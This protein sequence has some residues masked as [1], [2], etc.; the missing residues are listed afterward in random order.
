MKLAQKLAVNYLRARLNITAVV[1]K[2][3]AA[4]KAF[5]IFCTP[6]RR[7]KRKRPPIFDSAEKIQIKLHSTVIRGYRFNSSQPH[8][9]LIIHGFESSA[10]SFDRYISPFIKKGYEVLAFDAPGHGAS[11]GKQITLPMYI[12]MLRKVVEDFGPIDRFMAHSFGGLALA[13]LLESIPHDESTK[14][15]FLAPA[16][17]TTTAINSFFKFLDLNDNV[18]VAFDNVIVQKSGVHPSHFSIRRAMNGIDATILWIHDE[19]DQLTPI[20]DALKVKDD[21]HPNISFE[22]TNGLGHQKL[23]KENKVVKRVIEFL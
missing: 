6:Y 17:E 15:V 18:R 2:R 7:S 16:T 3:K 21:N 22:I 19:L 1:S 13:H 12:E 11:E 9:L 5:E 20:G 4:E 10:N 23:Y 14:A 8:K